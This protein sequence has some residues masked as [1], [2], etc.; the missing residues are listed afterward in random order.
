MSVRA[1]TQIDLARV[2]DGS[3]GTPGQNGAT[4]TPSV[5]VDGDIS[6]TNDGG[7]PNPPTQNIMG[8]QGS[9]GTPGANGVSVTSV[10]PQYY[11]STSDSSATGGSWSSTPAAF[12]SGR[13]YWTRDYITF[14]DGTNDTSTEVYNAGMTKAAQ[15]AYDAKTLADDTNQYFWYAPTGADTGAHITE[16]PQDEWNDSSDPNYHSG[17]NLLARSNGIAVRDGMT[18]LATF[19]SNV[20][21]V[22]QNANGHSRTEVSNAGMKIV[23]KDSNGND[24]QIA[25]LGYGDGNASSGTVSEK[26]YYTLGTRATTETP[27]VPNT[28]YERGDLCVYDGATYVYIGN[29]SVQTYW[30]SLLWIRT[31]GNY[32]VAEGQNVIASGASAHAEGSYTEAL[33]WRGHAEGEYTSAGGSSSHAEGSHTK[34]GGHNSHAEGLYTEASG[35]NSHAE[36]WVTHATADCSHAEGDGCV[37]SGDYSHAQNY[38]TIA[39]SRWQTAIGRYNIEDNI[40]TYAFIIGNGEDENERSNCFTVT[41]A[42][43]VNASG[44]IQDGFGNILAN[45]ANGAIRAGGTS[46]T[47]VSANSYTDV[48]ITFSSAMPNVPIVVCSIISTSTAGAIGSISVSPNDI[49]K[50]GFTARIFNAGSSART[51]ALSYIAYSA[52]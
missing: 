19:G 12:V 24:V 46:A 28:Y 36:G 4:F 31:I 23:Q 7:L 25:N 43:Y 21:R 13:Y 52:P 30:N 27:F 51:P 11:L 41:T 5:A 3:P 26:P 22:G 49:T 50:V 48:P 2:D 38:H 1:E 17:G 39:A 6:W 18:E 10:E 35:I 37:A 8:P 16:V 40:S 42:G 45:K 29:G 9:P 15:D 44:G 34:A 33:G 32:S 20:T 47:S 14:S